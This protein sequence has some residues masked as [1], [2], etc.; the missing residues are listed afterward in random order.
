M[1]SMATNRIKEIA[2]LAK[3]LPDSSWQELLDFAQFL[4]IKKEGFSYKKVADSAAYVRD[5]RKREG[6]RTRSGQTFINELI[7]WQKSNS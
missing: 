5:L 3:E 7:E 4:R 1:D 2:D 6:K